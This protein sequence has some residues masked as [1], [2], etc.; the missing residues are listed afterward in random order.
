MNG[1][2][3]IGCSLHRISDATIDTGEILAT[4]R[5]RVAPERSLLGNILALYPPGCGL[6][7]D[8]LEQLERGVA[9]RGTRQSVGAGNYYT[10]PT[11]DDW[12]QFTSRGFHVSLPA[13]LLSAYQRYFPSA[14]PTP[15]NG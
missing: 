12:S 2:D 15:A 4:A 6:I 14:Q 1:D 7:R 3:E 5:L 11:A 13:E 9:I 8:A 10:Y